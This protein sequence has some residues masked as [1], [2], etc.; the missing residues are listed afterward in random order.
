METEKF[1]KFVETVLETEED[2]TKME[3]GKRKENP[4]AKETVDSDAETETWSDY[5]SSDEDVDEEEEQKLKDFVRQADAFS[6]DW[7]YAENMN[8]CAGLVKNV[9]EPAA[10]CFLTFRHMEAMMDAME[11]EI[12]NARR[13]S[14]TLCRQALEQMIASKTKWK[15]GFGDAEF[16][17]RVTRKLLVYKCCSVWKQLASYCS[18]MEGRCDTLWRG[19]KEDQWK[20]VS[21]FKD[22]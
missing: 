8:A 9:G 13:A 5:G 20:S 3:S 15:P 4:V 1:D 11:D 22:M 12:L 21:M 18:L 2:D 16:A 6:A 19:S 14:M 10:R 17:S 7:A